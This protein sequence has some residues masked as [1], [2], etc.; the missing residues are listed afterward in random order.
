MSGRRWQIWLRTI[1]A[2]IA[3]P[4]FFLYYFL[5]PDPM[6]AGIKEFAVARTVSLE[7]HH[8]LS[9]IMALPATAWL[10]GTIHA[11]IPNKLGS[12]EV[13]FKVTIPAVGRDRVRRSLVAEIGIAVMREIDYYLTSGA[14]VIATKN[15]GLNGAEK[16]NPRAAMAY[17][18]AFQES[19]DQTQILYIRAEGSGF[20]LTPLQIRELQSYQEYLS[21]RNIVINFALGISFGICLYHLIFLIF[22]RKLFHIYFT[23]GLISVAIF[24]AILNGTLSDLDLSLDHTTTVQLSTLFIIIAVI[25]FILFGKSFLNL[26]KNIP[27]YNRLLNICLVVN[28]ILIFLA[29]V[30]NT[31]LITFAVVAQTVLITLDLTIRTLRYELLTSVQLFNTAIRG[32]LAGAILSVLSWFGVIPSN[33]V[34]DRAYILG[35]IWAGIFL[36]T[37]IVARAKELETGNRIVQDTLKGI[38]PKNRLNS[39]LR[40]SYLDQYSASEL[41]VTVMF[42][43]IVSFTKFAENSHNELVY[44]TLARRLD[45]IIKTIHNHGGSV[46][47]SLGDG[48]L[49]FF[50]YEKSRTGNHHALD[51]YRAAVEIQRTTLSFY[52]D[53][54]KYQID[55]QRKMPVRI[56]MHTDVVTIGNIGSQELT[57][58]TLV[59]NGVNFASRLETACNPFKVMVSAATRNLL[60]SKGVNKQEFQE[61]LIAVKHSEELVKAYEV[62]PHKGNES[63]LRKA[64]SEYQDSLG[65]VPRSKRHELQNDQLI[66]LTSPY[67]KFRVIDLSVDGFQLQG[68]HYLAPNANV[69]VQIETNDEH[70]NQ[71]LRS[72]FLDEIV[73]R[74]RWSRMNGP[75]YTHGANTVGGHSEQSR[76]LFALLLETNAN[77]PKSNARGG[78]F[79]A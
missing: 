47:R 59:G 56:G 5:S 61:I 74:I 78:Q 69:T 32:L 52:K 75:T 20:L 34:A 31:A 18:F 73:L 46:D 79:A 28:V 23:M 15:T 19:S 42:I 64:Y 72:L 26:G 21:V 57:D 25:S 71:R 35:Q 53:T 8:E 37:A 44:K 2:G 70:V 48:V 76:T 65:L 38:V 68:D 27:G 12:R 58:F 13:W 22:L 6:A 17:D 1:Q 40:D 30:I 67:G 24:A 77:D 33:I 14:S 3:L 66:Y 49:C 43:D 45:E 60:V 29:P 51:A 36:S 55:E 4:V 50:G 39:M 16:A 7:R 62:D 9:E 63:L 54:D 41:P 10:P 11:S